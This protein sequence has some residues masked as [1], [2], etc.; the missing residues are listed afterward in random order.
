MTYA[1]SDTLSQEL[2]ELASSKID[3]LTFNRIVT[4]DF[5]NLTAF[6]QDKIKRATL[7][8]AQFYE[9]YGIDTESLSGFSVSGL[10]MSFSG[11]SS[12]PSGVSPGANMLLK[13][14]GLM[15]R[16]V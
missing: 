1:T 5:T 13:Q 6:Q 8:Q 4:I 11:G 14:T 9:D 12:A 3:E 7:L 2:L 16:V 15:S 10:S